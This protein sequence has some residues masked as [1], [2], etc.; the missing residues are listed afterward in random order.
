MNKKIKTI[1]KAKQNLN[2]KGKYKSFKN[3]VI[4]DPNRIMKLNKSFNQKTSNILMKRQIPNT[5]LK[6]DYFKS[7]FDS[8]F[9]EF[10]DCQESQ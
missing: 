4:P 1:S 6:T 8:Y 9:V 10:S 5:Q 2:I 3:W 7:K